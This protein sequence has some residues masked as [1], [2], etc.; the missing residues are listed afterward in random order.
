MSHTH[1]QHPQMARQLLWHE[2][3]VT[4]QGGGAQHQGTHAASSWRCRR[5]GCPAPS[6]V[7]GRVA[8]KAQQQGSALSERLA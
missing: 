4:D 3:T 6:A 8:S 1:L 7:R 2:L 5:R